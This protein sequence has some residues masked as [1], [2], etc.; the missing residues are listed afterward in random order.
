MYEV[1][2]VQQLNI[3]QYIIEYVPV[4]GKVDLG[5]VFLEF[6]SWLPSCVVL[7]KLL[8]FSGIVAVHL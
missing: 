7:N 3:I 2:T 5:A 1:S 4:V 8:C 6:E